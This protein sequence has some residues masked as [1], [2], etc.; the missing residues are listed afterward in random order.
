M[1]DS[2]CLPALETNSDDETGFHV[3]KNGFPIDE[4][5][6]TRMWKIA[7]KIYPDA[8]NDMDEIMNSED[9]DEVPSIEMPAFTPQMSTLQCINSIQNYINTLSYNHTGTQLFEIR[10]SGPLARLMEKAKEMLKEGLPIKCLEAVILAIYLTNNLSNVERFPIG[11]KSVFN[12]HRYYH[13]VLG[14]YFNGHFG[15]LGISRR[16]DLM[17]KSLK[18]KNLYDLIA[19]YQ[20]AYSQYTHVL[21]KVRLGGLIPH[22]SHTHERIH[23]G[24]LNINFAKTTIPEQQYLLEHFSRGIRSHFTS[25]VSL[26]LKK[27]PYSGPKQVHKEYSV[28]TKAHK[29][30]TSELSKAGKAKA[31]NIPSSTYHVKI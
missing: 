14:I 20:S 12:G 27:E 5:T 1:T 23:W 15:A 6:W 7:S 11:F 31:G 8:K 26:F 19:D 3:N 10:K 21:K 2:K 4:K 30:Q 13:V 25:A 16:K 22:D 9:L 29:S 17:D 28:T 18:F 24:I